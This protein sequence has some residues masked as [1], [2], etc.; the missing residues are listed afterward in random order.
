MMETEIQKAY[1]LKREATILQ[2]E[3][4]HFL[5]FITFKTFNQ[6]QKAIDM[7]V[8]AGK[9]FR[10]FKHAESAAES[11]FFIGDIAHMDLRN[12]SLAIKYYTLAGCCYVDVDADRSLESYRKALALCIDSV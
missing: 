10:K 3:Q 12:Y 9:I 1:R 8:E 6:K 4:I 11:Y 5:D 2:N 7:F